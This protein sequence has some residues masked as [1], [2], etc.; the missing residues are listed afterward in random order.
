MSHRT[1]C[2]CT[3]CRVLRERVPLAMTPRS[4]NLYGLAG[5]PAPTVGSAALRSLVRRAARA[6]WDMDQC[7]TFDQH[8]DRII[9]DWE[10]ALNER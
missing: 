10:A 9:N 4:V 2:I 7:P 1:D 6:A 3:T 8:I 5:S